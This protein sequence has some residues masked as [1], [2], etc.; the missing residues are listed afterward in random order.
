[1]DLTMLRRRLSGD[2]INAMPL[3]HYEGPV[4]MIRMLEDGNVLKS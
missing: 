3:R 2:E 4:H 1:M